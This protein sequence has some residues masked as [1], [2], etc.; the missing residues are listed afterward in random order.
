MEYFSRDIPFWLGHELEKH[1]IRDEPVWTEN[2]INVLHRKWKKSDEN[3]QMHGYYCVGIPERGSL[4]DWTESI[5]AALNVNIS[6]VFRE[7]EDSP[8]PAVLH[9]D[10]HVDDSM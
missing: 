10:F 8:R 9:C 2:Y 4:V 5:A 7:I 6:L 1:A 3:M